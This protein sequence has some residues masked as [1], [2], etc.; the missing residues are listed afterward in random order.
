MLLELVLA[1]RQRQLGAVQGHGNLTEHI[2]RRA[3][4]VL[5]AVGQKHAADAVLVLDEI[6]Y[7]GNDQIHAQHVLFGE[8]GAAVHD[9]HILAVFH[10]G[11]ILA[12]FVY[13]AQRNNAELLLLLLCHNGLLS[14]QA[15]VF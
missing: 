8:D 12:K 5:M 7:V 9:Q 4:V 1:Q 6:G 13:A 2:G 14:C 3:D 15:G 10:H 11:D